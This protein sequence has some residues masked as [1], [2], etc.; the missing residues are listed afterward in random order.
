[1]MTRRCF[2]FTLIELLIVVAII[3][4][5]AAIAVPNFLEAQTRAKVSRVRADHR[6][7][8][9]AMESYAV[10]FNSYLRDGDDNPGFNLAAWEQIRILLRLTT[11]VAYISSV[12]YDPFHRNNHGNPSPY[13]AMS[14][15]F[16]GPPPYT[17]AYVSQGKFATNHGNPRT[18]GLLSVGPN[19]NFDSEVALD[20][21]EIN[22]IYDS[23]NG[24][25]S[26]GDI[27]RYGPGGPEKNYK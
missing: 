16:P 6:T 11:P 20:I 4:I 24:T 27:V 18:Y 21:G 25:I 19:S 12:P 26:M 5:L 17:Y 22:T 3:A 8:A 7:L 9:I 10:D 15:L 2:A 13:S 1:M 14:L 23:T